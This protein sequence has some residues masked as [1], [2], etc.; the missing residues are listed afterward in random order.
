MTLIRVEE[1]ELCKLINLS[2]PTSYLALSF[3]PRGAYLQAENSPWAAELLLK[4]R[5]SDPEGL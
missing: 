2:T 1:E 4:W 3:G 5:G